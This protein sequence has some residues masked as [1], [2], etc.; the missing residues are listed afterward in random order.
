MKK[1]STSFLVMKQAGMY[2]SK[3]IKMETRKRNADHQDLELNSK[4]NCTGID[5]VYF[6]LY[7]NIPI[8]LDPHYGQLILW[9]HSIPRHFEKIGIS[10]MLNHP[11]GEKDF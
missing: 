6:P 3:K 2:P 5:Y 4:R 8:T 10:S 9:D 7:K 11:K 1:A